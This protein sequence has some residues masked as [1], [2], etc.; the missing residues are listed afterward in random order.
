M[1][2]GQWFAAS[3]S[4]FLAATAAAQPV[5]AVI[6]TA[7]TGP[8]ITP[9][10]FGGFMEPATT[11]VWAEMLADRKFFNRVTSQ[12]DPAAVTGGFG[13]RGPQ[14]RWLPV[15]PDEFVAMG[16][17][18][19]YVGEW[20]PIVRLEPDS[21]HGISQS[22]L[23]LRAGRAY[24]GRV[25]LA[26]DPGA[27]VN[28][29]L[30]W[31]TGPRDRQTIPVP[32][33]TEGYAPVPLKFTAGA[34]TSD[35][36]LEIVGTGSGTFRVGVASLMPADNVSGFRA[37]SIR[38]LKELGIEIARWPGGNFVSAYDW[39][40]GI[41]DRDRRPPRREL[42]WSGL[43]SNDMG[44]DDFM[45]FC[46]LIG[47]MPYLAVNSG[48]G[49]AHS[50]AEEVE[51][52]N[53]PATSR[54]GRLRAANGHPAP[55]GVKIWGVGNEMYGPWQW[56]HM[57]ITQY[58]EKHNS[59]V[60]AMRKVDPTIEV[61]ASGATPEEASW[62]YIENR[63]LGTFPERETLSEPLPFAFG[64]SQDWTG[65]LLKA[66]ADQ[67]DYLGEHFYGY[68][69]LV[70]DPASQQFV[71]SDEPMEL[72]VRRLANRVQFKFEAWEEYLRRFPHLKDKRIRFAFDE[73]SPRNRGLSGGPPPASH[74][75]LNALTN[76]LVYH[77]FF[78]HSDDV[79]LAVATGGMGTLANDSYGDAIGLRL[80]GQVMKL[81]HDHFAGALPVA[82]SGDRPQRPTKGVVGIDTSARPSGSPTWPL[83]VFAALGAD[84]RTM[85]ISVVNPTETPQECDLSLAGTQAS[86][87]ARVYQLTAPPAGTTPPPPGPGAMFSGPP[88]TVAE[89]SLPLAPRRVS[90]P[91]TSLT[92]YAFDVTS[93][94]V[95]EA[96]P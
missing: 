1:H 37:A 35:G 20:S 50:A 74:P 81:L 3:I 43:E 80:E 65:A 28:V 44:I 24:A 8:P 57:L 41:G 34:D 58:A 39:R 73:W 9:F 61:I 27:R 75:M 40:D 46:R 2:R 38:H 31:G 7:R 68:P 10:V 6:D 71:L 51:Y 60:R 42:A 66:S 76:A 89:S 93:N 18:N 22:G 47:A 62:C 83:D 92:V 69:N 63:Q 36:R 49:D 14:R 78:R 94:R 96:K 88:A 52:V 67:I 86:G 23:V 77:E 82:V 33:P 79:G 5:A 4:F 90:L 11:R 48:L 16:E 95:E 21:P 19:A 54:L 25:A 64:S 55:Y 70:I 84:R 29:S 53:G 87:P 56:G 59:I 32:A 85:A 12:P 15:G 13:R 26:A 72:K 30:V 17:A 45:T 91:P